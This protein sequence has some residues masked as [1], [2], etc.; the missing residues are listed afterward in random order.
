MAKI[1]VSVVCYN[2]EE[3][4]ITFAKDLS[5][6]DEKGN[7]HL[8][9]TCNSCKNI[10]NLS[11]EL[12]E[13]DIS[14]ELFD[15]NKNLGY[16]NGC[17]YGLLKSELAYEWVMISNTDISFG[18]PNMM[19]HILNISDENIWCV[20]P[21]VMLTRN[22]KRQNPFAV[23]RPTKKKMLSRL[24]LYS[25]YPSY[26]LYF[27]LHSMRKK[28]DGHVERSSG[29]VYGVHGSCFFL[30]KECARKLADEHLDIFM[31]MEELA[32]AEMCRI[33]NKKVLYDDSI[34]VFHN[35]NQ[36][37]GKIKKTRKQRWFR[38]SIKIIVKRYFR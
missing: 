3:E 27:K 36:T 19:S 5:R 7:I 29:F 6:Q 12:K 20:G 9:V 30:R 8:V 23:S 4:L 13:L 31:Y 25:T 11:S 37:T 32:V 18:T 2:N 35:E 24:I 16:L 14:Y 33:N 17:L 28:T 1:I 21:N 10:S 26:L 15:P 22:G 38:D 34:Q